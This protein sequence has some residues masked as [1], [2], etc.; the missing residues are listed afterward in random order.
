V[1][2]PRQL[3]RV[4]AGAQRERRIVLHEDILRIH[5]LSQRC[6]DVGLLHDVVEQVRLWTGRNGDLVGQ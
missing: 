5:D 2:L 4:G 3:R 6:Q 1:L